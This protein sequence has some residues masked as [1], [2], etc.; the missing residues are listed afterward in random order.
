MELT[1]HV[2]AD[3]LRFGMDE[4]AV[5]AVLGEP[6]QRVAYGGDRTSLAF[7]GPAD[8]MVH[9]THGLVSITFSS[10]P[11]VLM[12]TDLFEGDADAVAAWLRTH[13][14]TTVERTNAEMWTLSA[15]S[16]GLVLYFD[17][18][19]PEFREVE[20]ISGTWSAGMPVG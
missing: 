7:G 17:D 11:A 12:G 1:P 15:P 6:V 2:G 20:L 16:L 14:E 4:A 18:D 8:V 9:A 3:A 10:G 13:G 19:D 5:R